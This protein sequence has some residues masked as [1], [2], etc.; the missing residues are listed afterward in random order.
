MRVVGL[1]GI[2]RGVTCTC[3]QHR[4]GG[5]A[6]Q[7]I[8]HS[9]S[10]CSMW[11]L[12]STHCPVAVIILPGLFV[13][14][15]SAVNSFSAACVASW[16]VIPLRLCIRGTNPEKPAPCAVIH[17]TRGTVKLFISRTW[18]QQTAAQKSDAYTA[19][20]LSSEVKTSVLKIRHDF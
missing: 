16:N 10:S 3:G 8:W 19:V 11:S 14:Y 1:S 7:P 2:A 20:K 13:S 18:A 9:A 5:S 17:S 6:L 12:T 15:R 4:R